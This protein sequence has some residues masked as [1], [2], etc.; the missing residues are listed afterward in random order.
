MYNP[1]Q[2]QA[3][4][5][6]K[7]S[8]LSGR[9][10]SGHFYSETQIAKEIGLSRTPVRGAL[11]QLQRSKLVEIIPN[12]GFMVWKMTLKDVIETYQVRSAIEGYAATQVA[13]DQAL[14]TG[15]RIIR[16]LESVYAK[17]VVLTKEPFNIDALSKIDHDFHK[18]MVDYLNNPSLS[19]LFSSHFFRI[20]AICINTFRVP[21]RPTIA[22]EEHRAILEALRSGQR[23]LAYM[24]ALK[25][26]ENVE[27][28]MI[29]VLKTAKNDI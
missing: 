10:Q 5:Y 26:V 27:K 22:L 23:D 15:K 8:I 29:E 1:L 19:E 20:Q 9:L 12:K 24:M 18:T 7:T 13:N 3:Y 14:G 2:N 6:L 4:D 21:N 16:L 25:H 17:Q 28:L 11:Q